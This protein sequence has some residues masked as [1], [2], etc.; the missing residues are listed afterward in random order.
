[1]FSENSAVIC[2]H[3]RHEWTHIHAVETFSREEDAA[4]G[5][6]A[7]IAMDNSYDTIRINSNILA[8]PSPR[9]DSIKVYFSC[10]ACNKLT[11]LRIVQHKGMDYLSF[12]ASLRK[13][14][15]ATEEKDF[16]S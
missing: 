12:H 4:T 13:G 14:S 2:A 7:V 15:S 3:C 10:E 8:N 9:R 16:D 11:E 6:H 1:M 5:V